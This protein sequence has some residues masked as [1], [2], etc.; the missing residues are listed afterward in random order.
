MSMA[1]FAARRLQP[2]IANTA[3]ILGIE[4]LAA[5]QGIEF[6]R[7]LRSSAALEAAHALLRERCP[8]MPTD[9]YLAPDIERA[10]ALVRR[11]LAGAHLANPAGPAGALESGLNSTTSSKG[12]S[13]EEAPARPGRWPLRLAACAQ[14]QDTKVA[15]GISGWTGFAPLTLAKEAGLFKKHG[16]DVT[17]KKIPQ[18]DRHL[19][20]RLGRHPVRRD[21][22][23]DLGR[24]ER[25]TAWRRRR[26]SSSTRATAP[27]AWSS[28]PASP[29]SP[30]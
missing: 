30:T 19:A 4:L 10:T 26:S 1:T 7:P 2:M 12:T 9:R 17:I 25:R 28:S 15:I 22:G 8:P 5:A 11:W 6:L 23:R 16:L 14:A 27:T 29:R 21:H 18:K 24:L 3:H 20:H 13:H